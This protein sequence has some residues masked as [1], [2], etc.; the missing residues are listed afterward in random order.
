MRNWM[1]QLGTRLSLVVSLGVSS[2]A[3][4]YPPQCVDVCTC[5][6]YC[7]MD[8]YAGTTFK[9]TCG[10]DG[11]LCREVC[12]VGAAQASLSQD[13][14]EQQDASRDVCTEQAQPSASAE[15]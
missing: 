6:S 4:A 2:T 8:C 1:K 11:A 9:T 5:E 3:L 7:N 15:S 12:G 13:A 14:Q 10:E